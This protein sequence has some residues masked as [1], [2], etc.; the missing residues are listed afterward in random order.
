MVLKPKKLVEGYVKKSDALDSD[1]G[2]LAQQ[3]KALRVLADERTRLE[4]KIEDLEVRIEEGLARIHSLKSS[5]F[6]AQFEENFEN[7]TQVSDRRHELLTEVAVLEDE[8]EST[9]KELDSVLINGEEVSALAASV[10][11]V[12]LPEFVSFLW[13]LEQALREKAVEQQQAIQD[14]KNAIPYD[15]AAVLASTP[16][17]Y[18]A[19]P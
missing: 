1:I 19:A 12:S 13:Q 15:Y 14:V 18:V 4:A 3:A 17:A 16:R 11:A 6:E 5:F 10:E 9:Q 2:E 7:I 8:K